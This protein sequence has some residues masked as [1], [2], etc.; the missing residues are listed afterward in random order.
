MST[1]FIPET[2]E[3]NWSKTPI[4]GESR[5]VQY[6]GLDAVTIR[7]SDNNA[8][9]FLFIDVDSKDPETLR[10]VLNICRDKRLTVYF[11]ETCKGWHVISPCLLGIRNWMGI[12]MR[13][14]KFQ[15]SSG[16]T[17]RWTPRHCDGKMLHYQSWNTKKK[18]HQESYDLHYHLHEKFMC[19][20]TPEKLSNVVSTKLQWKVYN[21]L[22]LNLKR[23]IQ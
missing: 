16:D 3:G 4:T 9:F 17:I 23:H 21:Q 20:L 1:D 13:L 7:N 11:Y 6:V 19:D 15:D 12:L 8:F 14:K 22:R 2:I 18:F 5:Y 10:N